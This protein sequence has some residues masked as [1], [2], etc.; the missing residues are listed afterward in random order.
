MTFLP[1]FLALLAT[2][3][4]SCDGPVGPTGDLAGGEVLADA[5][6]ELPL[7]DGAIP[8]VTGSL[9]ATES[10]WIEAGA[11]WSRAAS[12][13]TQMVV[14][15]NGLVLCN[16]DQYG[17]SPRQE[18]LDA[19]RKSLEVLDAAGTRL[20]TAADHL[21]GAV[22]GAILQDGSVPQSLSSLPFAL[23]VRDGKVVER[24]RDLAD[25]CKA[26]S[27][28]V[29]TLLDPLDVVSMSNAALDPVV[30][31]L[32]AD[33]ALAVAAGPVVATAGSVTRTVLPMPAPAAL[34]VE[35]ASQVAAFV[36]EV[37]VVAGIAD[38]DGTAG[39][40][41]LAAEAPRPLVWRADGLAPTAADRAVAADPAE[42]DPMEGVLATLSFPHPAAAVLD[43][44]PL[45][46]ADACWTG[47]GATEAACSLAATGLLPPGTYVDREN[48]GALVTVE[49]ISLSVARRI[50][51]GLDVD[52]VVVTL[53]AD[54]DAAPPT[55][56]GMSPTEGPVGTAIT[57][58]GSGFGT[59][60]AAVRVEFNCGQW[61][62]VPPAMVS[63]VSLTAVFPP[64]P[65]LDIAGP[66]CTYNPSRSQACG[67]SVRVQ[68]RP[69]WGGY[70]TL[71]AMPPCPPSLQGGILPGTASVGDPVNVYGR[72]FS[73]NP[74]QN[75]A[76]FGGGVVATASKVDPDPYEPELAR[77]TFVVPEG[78]VTGDV[79]FRNTEGIG[80]WSSS[81]SPLTIV[82][83]T[84]PVL[85]PGPSAGGLHVPCLAMEAGR[86]TQQNW[87]H[88][89]SWVLGQKDVG[90]LD[91]DSPRSS[92]GLAVLVDT[93]L[94]SARLPALP[95]PDGRL[96]LSRLDDAF[97]ILAGLRPGDTVTFRAQG[98][99]RAN[100]FVR[101]S[102]PLVLPVVSRYEP[103]TF[104]TFES[105]VWT[106][107]WDPPPL[108][109]ALG[110][111]LVL[112][113]S[114]VNDT[115]T[116]P[117]LWEGT[118][119][120]GQG[121][122][123]FPGWEDFSYLRGIRVVMDHPGTFTVT[124]GKG[125]SRV[126]EVRR[127]GAE[128][129]G[130]LAFYDFDKYINVPVPHLA[131]DGGFLG[132]GGVRVEI[133]PGAL[134]LHDGDGGYIVW[135]QR[136]PLASMG[137]PELTAGGL[138]TQVWFDPEPPALLKPV[139]ITIPY[140]PEARGSDAEL[141]LYDP[142][143][144]LYA[145]LPAETVGDRLRLVLP[146]GTYGT[147]PAAPTGAIRLLASSPFPLRDL[148]L[149]QV[150]GALV[151]AAYKS[152]KGVLKDDVRQ[153]QVNYVATP[154]E[155][156]HVSDSYAGEVLAAAQAAWDF[157]TREGWPKPDGW[158]GG[159]IVLTI[160]DMG[161]LTQAAEGSTTK[162]VFGQPWVTI[163]SQ[164]AS[165]TQ[166]ATTTAHEM[167]HV[168]QRQVNNVFSLK[169][170]D[171]AAAQWTA[172]GALGSGADISG[173]ITWAS[174]FPSVTLPPTFGSGWSLSGG[175]SQ[176][177]AYAAGA[178]TV[179]MESV[180]R[181]SVLRV[182]EQ[183]RD[184]YLAYEDARG[185]LAAAAG[186]TVQDLIV[187]FG[188]AYWGQTLDLVKDLRLGAA[189]YRS[190][191]DW[192]GMA[193][194]DRR[195]P[196]SS[197]R[198][199]VDLG[200]KDA[201]MAGRDL[202]VRSSGLGAG[203]LA[204]IYRDAV[205]CTDAAPRMEQVRLL[206]K[207][208]PAGLLGPHGMGTRCYRVLILNFSSTE[209]ADVTVTLSTPQ[210]TGV[211]P[212]QGKNDGG[213]SITLSG[214][215]FGDVPGSVHLAGFRLNVTAWSD[216]SITAT[217]FNAGTMTGNV[218]LKVLTTEGAWSNAATFTL[219]D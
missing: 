185:T 162:G 160:T 161:P 129:G 75:E 27:A 146:A 41:P 58:S 8:V 85:L 128:G 147:A 209:T 122:P 52:D 133:P 6:S 208:H 201:E 35:G 23:A 182:Y 206:D 95:L 148:S 14:A 53:P 170:I 175:Y 38:A 125:V 71:I 121:T 216:Q 181:G 37:P 22:A 102:E 81:T 113:P 196:L 124:N 2:T 214:H 213:Y 78:A 156:S 13:A 171:E 56:S 19:A 159:W 9:T 74:S 198:W 217:M 29:K 67:V 145:N 63:D 211:S 24:L 200:V 16:V 131:Q 119:S 31:A 99:E 134:P 194:G 114:D 167:G 12:A 116:A 64:R 169:W 68:G 195:P 143:S 215:G 165:G 93:R 43:T 57:I 212:S 96:L 90:L 117:G 142:A 20:A 188:K 174:G 60:P 186:R 69:A 218:D 59:D 178:F 108:E 66:W 110:D 168:F 92:I 84:V 151:A 54:P 86:P 73:P 26:E 3:T 97:S 138:Q 44:R 190:W 152:Q 49:G 189:P 36:G 210:V 62:I 164:C 11:A 65:T 55:I 144:G 141:G 72:G 155:A 120:F 184:S 126:V 21:E 89:F 17:Q 204:C 163:N 127:E 197:L 15:V 199:D 82:P 172:V 100:L 158:F 80:E 157:M 166:V 111:A 106:Y 51:A 1:V 25:A 202:V 30:T 76:R 104:Q 191:V 98:R 83:P 105:S 179:W 173:D 176:Q 118:L 183:L 5:T 132:C 150:L 45:Q 101:T 94:G 193:V 87:C 109:V 112:T 123:E 7:P 205:P 139:T 50:G 88:D 48:G 61:A 70:F 18:R 219:V 47:Q 153:L 149:N 103:G 203:Q 42:S 77:V 207:D 40:V 91:W 192:T 4:P 136:T 34:A 154:G 177:Q 115:L 135:C 39:A 137:H 10:A 46:G 107:G 33:P 180:S 32:S 28:R 140:D 79:S 130:T 187:E